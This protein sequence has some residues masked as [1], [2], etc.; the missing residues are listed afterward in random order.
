M[1][2]ALHRHRS[3]QDYATPPEFIE[4]VEARF[5]AL[6]WD[7]AASVENA[8]APRHIDVATNSFSARWYS[9]GG[10][11]WLNPPYNDITPWVRKC[12][13]ESLAGAKILALLPASVGSNWYAA[14]VDGC[15]ARVLFLRPRISFDGQ[16]PFPKDLMLVAYGTDAAPGVECWKWR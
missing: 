1:G 2:A 5:G 11:L 3:R 14:Y 4:A 9:L 6:A 7:L 13:S 16:N 8:K 10:L 15:A 12:H